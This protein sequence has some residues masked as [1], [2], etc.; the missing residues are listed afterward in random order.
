MARIGAVGEPVAEPAPFVAA[1]AAPLRGDDPTT[2]N[3]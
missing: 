3:M 2:P 1:A